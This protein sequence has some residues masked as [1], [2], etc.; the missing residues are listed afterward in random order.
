MLVLPG[1][2]IATW[3]ADADRAAIGP[4][5]IDV[6]AVVSEHRC[7]SG[8]GIG[9][10]LLPP[11][12]AYSADAITVTFSVRPLQGSHDCQGSPPT[13]VVVRLAQALGDR[14]LLDGA[15]F[16]PADPFAPDI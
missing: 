14:R 4:D 9:D 16:P 5:T 15:F 13:R 8:R 11:D 10:R 3:K 6:P 1:R 12:I 2:T 7:T